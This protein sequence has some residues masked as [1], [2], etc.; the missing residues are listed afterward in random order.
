M[1]DKCCQNNVVQRCS[2]IRRQQYCSNVQALT[3]LMKEQVVF[4][5]SN[6]REQ[7]CLIFIQNN[8]CAK[9][10]KRIIGNL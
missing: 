3:T 8:K 1:L 9:R 2:F 4:S 6:N 7:H 10:L 5:C